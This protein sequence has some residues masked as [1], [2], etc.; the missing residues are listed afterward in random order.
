MRKIVDGETRRVVVWKRGLVRVEDKKTDDGKYRRQ[1]VELRDPTPMVVEETL[2]LVRDAGNG[3]KEAW[4]REP[5]WDFPRDDDPI[6]PFPWWRRLLGQRP[7]RVPRA[8]TR[9]GK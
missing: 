8:V 4:D 3:W 5:C 9:V 1:V 7:P 6:P 2:E